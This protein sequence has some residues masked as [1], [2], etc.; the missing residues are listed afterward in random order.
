MIVLKK[1]QAEQVLMF[2]NEKNNA[3]AIAY[4][5]HEFVQDKFT[6]EDKKVFYEGLMIG[7]YS[8]LDVVSIL[9]SEAKEKS[10]SEGTE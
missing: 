5:F 8:G 10:H 9:V 3:E 2:M 1:E 6:E 7:F 4:L